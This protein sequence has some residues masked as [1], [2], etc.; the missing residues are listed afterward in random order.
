MLQGRGLGQR[1]GV[2]GDVFI[3][4]G[5]GE[6]GTA[7]VYVEWTFESHDFQDLIINLFLARLKLF[8]LILERFQH[9][10]LEYPQPKFIALREFDQLSQDQRRAVSETLEVLLEHVL[11]DLIEH[12]RLV[13]EYDFV[14]RGQNQS[15]SLYEAMYEYLLLAGR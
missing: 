7:R 5:A 3:D 6:S 14:L 1:S 4:N 13:S 12:F 15:H 2:W 8:I 11:T 9:F 10:G